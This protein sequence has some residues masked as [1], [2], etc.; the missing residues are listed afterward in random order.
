SAYLMA[1]GSDLITTEMSSWIGRATAPTPLIVM[2]LSDVRRYVDATGDR[3]PLWCDDDYAKAAGYQG[4]ILP[5]ALVGWVPFSI[6]E[7]P[8]GS[9][10]EAPDLRRQIP[11]PA[12][13]TN[14]RNAGS[15]TEWL[16]PVYPGESLLTQSCLVDI[17]ARQGRA[18][19]GI[20]ITQEEQILN[21]GGETVM[22]RR[23]TMALFPEAKLAGAAKE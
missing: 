19:L 4:R 13:Y 15:E 10:A 1:D 7:N 16:Q 12:N 8:D 17:I 23:H 18:G 3:N 9:S 11:V 20:Y 14:V 2:T 21:S 6:R 5:P 22:R